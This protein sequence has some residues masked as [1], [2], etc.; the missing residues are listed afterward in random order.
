M[1]GCT[2]ECF[3]T[4]SRALQLCSCYDN[5]FATPSQATILA[6][7]DV[8]A[9][10][11]LS[12]D[13]V[14]AAVRGY[15]RTETEHV[16]VLPGMIAAL[17]RDIR[18]DRF[19]RSPLEAR[20]ARSDEADARLAALIEEYPV[21]RPV[22]DDGGPHRYERPGPAQRAARSVSCPHCL[23]GP[24][25]RCRVPGTRTPLKAPAFHPS[26]IDAAAGSPSPEVDRS[27]AHGAHS[28]GTVSGFTSGPLCSVCGVN[29]LGAEE[30][31]SR[32]VCDRCWP[33]TNGPHPGSGQDSDTA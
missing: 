10:H 5:Q 8:F 29:D 32:G 14:L 33:H 9:Y 30:Q 25:E 11:R 27:A 18:Q 28:G 3:V 4:A 6:W 17:A 15:Y 2:N 20:E 21:G 22:P 24:G 23:A 12:A 26:R 19:Q 13:D 31:C 16:V 7:A 1:M